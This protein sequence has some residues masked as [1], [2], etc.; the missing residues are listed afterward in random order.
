F[1]VRHRAAHR[2]KNCTCRRLLLQ[3]FGEVGRALPKFI[4]Q[5]RILN[6]DDGLGGEGPEKRYLL[7]RKRSNFGTSKL[8]CSDRHSLSQQWNTGDR[9]V[10]EPPRQG[11]SFGKVLDLRLEV[12]YM[13]GLPLENGA[14][15]NTSTRARETK[16]LRVWDCAP[17]G[18][19]T[20]VLPIQFEKGYVVR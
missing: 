4:Q 1:G 12:N 9:P 16:T 5:P 15:R 18:G 11:A 10:S 20:Y 17:V 2:R 8:E 19:F 7:I 14:A 13:N 3:R 6:G